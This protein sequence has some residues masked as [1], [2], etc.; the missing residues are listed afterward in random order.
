MA[1]EETPTCYA[2][3]AALVIGKKM[4]DAHVGFFGDGTIDIWS[5][6][7]EQFGLFRGL[8]NL[9]MDRGKELTPR[10]RKAWEAVLERE[11]IRREEAEEERK[12]EEE[13][14]K[15]IE[16][17]LREAYQGLR[18][19]LGMEEDIPAEGIGAL[20]DQITAVLPVVEEKLKQARENAEAE[21]PSYAVVFAEML[22]E[23]GHDVYSIGGFGTYHVSFCADGTLDINSLPRKHFRAYQQAM[24]DVSDK[25]K[26][27]GERLSPTDQRAWDAI[28]SKAK[29]WDKVD[30]EEAEERRKE[31]I[32]QQE[33]SRTKGIII[34]VACL[35][36]L[37][38][39]AYR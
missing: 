27:C 7:D 15:E 28:E 9:Y 3:K 31:R 22:K 11:E 39:M 24:R 25:K 17:Q 16:Q 5:L 23:Q 4:P 13:K 19:S 34:A 14:K 32:R 29:N 21:E 26:A 38:L 8:M 6:T 10:D 35:V 1:T 37:L 36:F 2:E 12:K 20:F 18:S 30:A 33:E